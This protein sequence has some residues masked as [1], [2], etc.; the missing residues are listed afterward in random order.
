MNKSPPFKLLHELALKA[1]DKAFNA[2]SD[3]VAR[4]KETEKQLVML[5]QYRHDYVKGLQLSMSQ[6]MLSSQCQNTQHFISTLDGAIG[7]QSN[8]LGQMQKQVTIERA[9]WLQESRKVASMEALIKRDAKRAGLILARKEQKSNDEF[10]ARA[11]Q[12]LHA[13]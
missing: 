10:A 6:G 11:F 3:A 1:K 9:R 8:L 7:Q 4:E 12:R 5:Q 2:V 13:I